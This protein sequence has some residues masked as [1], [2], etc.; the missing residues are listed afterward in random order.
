MPTIEHIKTI[1]FRLPM[2]GAL[3][4]GKH[5]VM[6]EA[7]HVLVEVYLS[8]GAVGYTEALPRPTIYGETAA[9]ICHIIEAEL[10][11]RLIGE[12]AAALV[13]SPSTLH[14]SLHQIKN[15]QTAIGAVDI[16]LQHAWTVSKGITLAE[17]LGAT[18]TQVRTSYILGIGDNDTMLA[19]AQQVYEAGVRVL[20][21]KVGRD[22]AADQARITLLRDIGDDLDLYVDANETLTLE[23]A[24][25]RLDALRE[26]GILYCEEPIPVEY[27][28]ERAA[29][30]AGNHMPLIGDDSCFS[31]RDLRRELAFDTFDILN[32]KCA[33][34][35]YTES[36][37]MLDLAAAAGK[38]V[39]VGSQASS[40][41][42]AA[43][44]AIF[45][46]RPEVNCPSEISFWLKMK[47]D[48]VSAEIPIRD[49]TISVADMLKVEVDRDLLQAAYR[50]I[51]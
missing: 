39:M 9:S 11:P 10:K 48:I 28:R 7:H 25:Y 5:S 42:G 41:L 30:R 14:N 1:P 49:G 43:R 19:E 29:L 12:S 45:A 47:E 50:V 46:A 26:L 13:N 17:H 21:V 35:G 33:R 20:K 6:A 44:S 27:I 31:V 24:A 32:I 3:R 4:W 22:L 36:C 34:S 23:N 40:R 18:Q 2:R 37:M 8:D 51:R 16:A 15:N 38:Q